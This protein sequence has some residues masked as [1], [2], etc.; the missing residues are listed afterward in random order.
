VDLVFL[1]ETTSFRNLDRHGLDNAAPPP[2]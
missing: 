1:G 2:F